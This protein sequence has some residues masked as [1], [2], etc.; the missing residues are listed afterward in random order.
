MLKDFIQDEEEAK[1]ALLGT[2]LADG[3]LQKE[4]YTSSSKTSYRLTTYVEI[5]HTSKNLD[6]LKE[7]KAIFETI[8][9]VKCKITEHNKV[10]KD[11]TYTL[12]RLITNSTKYF[13]EL[14]DVLYD[15]KRNKL[16]PKEI[17]IN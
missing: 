1:R 11:K 9:G 3:S 16:F 6:Y 17:F 8:K 10:S 13:K 12:Y 4:R 15:T 5:T 2:I 14:R 7:V